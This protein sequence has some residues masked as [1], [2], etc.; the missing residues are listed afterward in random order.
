M[1]FKGGVGGVIDVRCCM[2]AKMMVLFS[3]ILY[4]GNPQKER[5]ASFG[6]EIL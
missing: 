4:I 1:C 2:Q 5:I 3:T 6:T